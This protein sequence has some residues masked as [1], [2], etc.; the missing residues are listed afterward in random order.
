M[1]ISFFKLQNLQNKTFFKISNCFYST[2]V[3]FYTSHDVHFKLTLGKPQRLFWQKHSITYFVRNKKNQ[4]I[5]GRCLTWN[6]KKGAVARSRKSSLNS[7]MVMSTLE[8]IHKYLLIFIWLL[9]L[10]FL[11]TTVAA[12]K[13]ETLKKKS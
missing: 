4:I 11:D 7:G 2:L 8:I 10:Y 1:K 12:Q 13:Y 9:Y 3:N 5:S 6:T